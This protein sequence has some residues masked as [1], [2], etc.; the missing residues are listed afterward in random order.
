VRPRPL[1]L[2]VE[3]GIYHDGAERPR[4]HHR[5]P[6]GLRSSADALAH[7]KLAAIDRYLVDD[8]VITSGGVDIRT[9]DSFKQ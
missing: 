1:D 5:G 6:S 2:R 3:L 4:Q 7:G 8:F 9:R